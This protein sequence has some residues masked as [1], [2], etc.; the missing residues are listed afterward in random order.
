M[1]GILKTLRRVAEVAFQEP[2][3]RSINGQHQLMKLLS[4]ACYSGLL[5]QSPAL[6]RQYLKSH[7]AR[8][9]TLGQR[10]AAIVAHYRFVQ[11]QLSPGFYDRL[12]TTGAMLWRNDEVAGNYHIGLRHNVAH[13]YE[14]DLL[15][16]FFRQDVLLFQL[17]FSV[18]PGDIVGEAAPHV[19][20]VGGAQGAAP[21]RG[22]L[23]PAVKASHGV[24]PSHLAMAALQGVA[25]ALGIATIVGVGNDQ[26]LLKSRDDKADFTFD[27]DRFW[28]MFGAEA[29]AAG[30]WA[31]PAPLRERDPADSGASAAHRRRS[32][33]KGAFKAEVRDAA[34]ATMTCHA[35]APSSPASPAA[36]LPFA[37]ETVGGV[38]PEAMPAAPAP[39]VVARP[40]RELAAA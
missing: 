1:V 27:Y 14:G 19:L 24:A 30:Q 13:F 35:A 31:M 20:F 37:G 8:S 23:Q 29:N 40:V 15:L 5:D 26:Q 3:V 38:R 2:I 11:A 9:L 16:A 17:S 22:E 6:T 21:E 18:V 10:R 25:M 7:L 4:S 39:A 12:L 36:P 28:A 33:R 34:R 32:R